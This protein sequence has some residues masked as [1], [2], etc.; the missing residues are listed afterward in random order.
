L[1]LTTDHGRGIRPQDWTSH[2][3]NTPRSDET[4][5]AVMG[6]DTP[7]MRER[8]NVPEVVTAQVAATVAK[9]LGQDYVN[10]FPKAAPP[11]ADF[12]PAQKEK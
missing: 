7:A 8:R 2:G 12:F 6:P 1:I 11:I 3:K 9:F 5:I 10:A 4:W